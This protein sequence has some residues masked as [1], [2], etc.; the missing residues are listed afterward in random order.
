MRREQFSSGSPWESSVGYSRAVRVGP[1]VSVAG[2]TSTESDD[3]YAQAHHALGK[4]QRA[5]EEAGAAVEDVTRTRI[6]VLRMGDA[7]AVGRAHAEYF[8][9]VRPACTIVEVSAL[10]SMEMLVEIEAEAII[11]GPYFSER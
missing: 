2:T 8:G 10:I 6:Y 3:A 5:L 7:E 11:A 9:A 4:I 1:F